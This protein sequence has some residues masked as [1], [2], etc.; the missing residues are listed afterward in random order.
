MKNQNNKKIISNILIAIIGGVCTIAAAI[1]GNQHGIKSQDKY[2][3][4]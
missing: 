4:S 1:L 3:Q 2:I